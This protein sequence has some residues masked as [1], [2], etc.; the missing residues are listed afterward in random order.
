MLCLLIENSKN[1]Q[2]LLSLHER[3]MNV[4]FITFSTIL[5]FLKMGKIIRSWG[6]RRLLSEHIVF[7][8]FAKFSSGQYLTQN[9]WG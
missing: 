8:S 7:K 6:R 4:H 3:Y 5:V 2:A 1:S 9:N